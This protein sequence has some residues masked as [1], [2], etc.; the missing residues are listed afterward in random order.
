MHRKR[1]KKKQFALVRCA[2]C[3]FR[4]C[5]SNERCRGMKKKTK[6]I[7]QKISI[8]TMPSRIE[9][10]VLTYC[11]SP[12]ISAILHCDSQESCQM[13][14]CSCLRAKAIRFLLNKKPCKRYQTSPFGGELYFIIIMIVWIDPSDQP[15]NP[16][17]SFEREITTGPFYPNL[18]STANTKSRLWIGSD[19]IKCN[20]VSKQEATQV[21]ANS[22]WAE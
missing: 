10:C 16:R 9:N 1:R 7:I 5:K 8:R 11:K 17:K 4:W 14:V 20:S 2:Q 6:R 12:Y 13:F 19:W 22:S 18:F 21:P 15:T 3:W